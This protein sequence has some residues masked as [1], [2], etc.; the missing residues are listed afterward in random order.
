MGTRCDSGAGA[1]VRGE[2]WHAC[3]TRVP[4]LPPLHACTRMHTLHAHTH[5][6]CNAPA[7]ERGRA[8]RKDSTHALKEKKGKSMESTKRAVNYLVCNAAR[9]HC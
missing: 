3:A 7:R 2:R 9:R 4:P 8:E 6:P 5:T 1:G